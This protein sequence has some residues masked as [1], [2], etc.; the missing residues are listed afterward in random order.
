M[1]QIGNPFIKMTRFFKDL[2]EPVILVYNGESEKEMEVTRSKVAA[3]CFY[4]RTLL[5]GPFRESSQSRIDIHLGDDFS[6]ETFKAVIHYAND[7]TFTRFGKNIDHYLEIIQLASL[8]MY[9]ELVEVVE[10]HLI[11]NLSIS[12]S[13]RFHTLANIF[14]LRRLKEVC[15]K[16]EHLEFNEYK[17]AF[18]YNVLTPGHM[19]TEGS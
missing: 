6:F 10:L 1:N 12:L 18:A 13:A 15:I 19:M 14:D 4:F 2:I 7:K 16:I 3:S 8:W 17:S 11:E 9:D 5:C